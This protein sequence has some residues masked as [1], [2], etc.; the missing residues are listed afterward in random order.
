[1]TEKSSTPPY[2]PHDIQITGQHWRS[3]DLGALSRTITERG[4]PDIIFYRQLALKLNRQ[5]TPGQPLVH[6]GQ[7]NLY[8]TLQKIYRHLI[9]VLAESQQPDLLHDALRRAG[10]NPG[11]AEAAKVQ[12]RFVELFPPEDVL[13][14]V[15]DPGGWLGRD[16]TAT[17]RQR[18]VLRELLLRL[19]TLG[20]NGAG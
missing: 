6:A 18:A 17:E 15:V 8:V 2:F 1:M 4:I 20:K 9:D 10:M 12:A 13:A 16:D 14:G 5:R 19:V 3:L 11:G 7:L